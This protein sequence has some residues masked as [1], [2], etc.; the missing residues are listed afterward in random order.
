MYRKQHCFG[1]AKQFILCLKV[2]WPDVL[3]KLSVDLWLDFSL[4]VL[5]IQRLDVSSDFQWNPGSLRHIDGDVG[6]FQWSNAADKT[7]VVLL[8]FDQPILT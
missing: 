7:E 6:A 5:L 8:V 2:G 1:V 4:K 3:D